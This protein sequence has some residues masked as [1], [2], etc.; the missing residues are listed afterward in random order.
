MVTEKFK[1]KP[2]MEKVSYFIYFV[3][4]IFVVLSM[5]TAP[6]QMDVSLVIGVILFFIGKFLM[7]KYENK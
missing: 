4:L 6:A 3:A 7:K 2:F 5:I 1:S